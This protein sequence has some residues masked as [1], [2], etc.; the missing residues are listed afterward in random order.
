MAEDLLELWE[1]EGGPEREKEAGDRGWNG[2]SFWIYGRK[3][4][5]RAGEISNNYKQSIL[6]AE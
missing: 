4:R 1:V 3:M 2:E 5:R 6:L